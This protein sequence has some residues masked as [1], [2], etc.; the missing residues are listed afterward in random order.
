MRIEL[1]S[2]DRAN[3]RGLWRRG[4]GKCLCWN[5]PYSGWAE[6]GHE[7]FKIVL[8]KKNVNE[9]EK[10]GGPLSVRR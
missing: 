2:E 7:R 9:G 8:Q 10:A 6:S 4:R 5:S 3:S 1:L